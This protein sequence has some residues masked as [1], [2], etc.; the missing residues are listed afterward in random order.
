MKVLILSDPH[1]EFSP[2]ELP[3]GLEFDVVVLA[4]DIHSPAAKAVRWAGEGTRFGGKPVVYVPGNHEFY[5]TRMDH[6]IAEMRAA[7]RVNGV[8]FLDGDQVLIDGVRFLGATLWT[9][10]ELNIQP[11]ALGGSVMDLERALRLASNS[12]ND[13]TLIR[14]PDEEAEP[15]TWRSKQGRRLQAA[16]TRQIHLSQ[17]EWLSRMLQEEFSWPTVVVTHHA[18]H[19]G[20]LAARHASDWVFRA[21]VSELAEDLFEVPALWIHGH[22]HQNL[23]YRVGSCRVVTNPRGYVRWGGAMENPAFNPS[24]IVDLKR[25][26]P[27]PNGEKR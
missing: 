23:D 12:L 6:A 7:A 2:F 4:G 8:H 19:R 22:I 11:P 5:D 3:A 26:A 10:F 25:P 16:D 21:R 27:Q 9:D 14:T 13:Y 17:R 18:P 15:D 20:S 24:L 1:L